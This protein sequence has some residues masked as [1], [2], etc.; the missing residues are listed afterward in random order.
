MTPL[1]CVH[2]SLPARLLLLKSAIMPYIRTELAEVDRSI[3]NEKWSMS[4]LNGT[5]RLVQRGN[6][7]GFKMQTSSK[8]TRFS[9]RS[10]DRYR[11]RPLLVSIFIISCYKGMDTS[12]IRGLIP[13]SRH[14]ITWKLPFWTDTWQLRTRSH[15]IW[16][17]RLIGSRHKH[18]PTE[19]ENSFTHDLSLTMSNNLQHCWPMFWPRPHWTILI[20]NF[21]RQKLRIVER[22]NSS[23]VDEPLA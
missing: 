10:R 18:F 20:A 13:R 2:V 17:C 6:E 14:A 15:V 1:T 11:S 12:R 8:L 19:L 23:S 4:G 21:F 3:R 7:I 5:T 22:Q 16:I 9:D